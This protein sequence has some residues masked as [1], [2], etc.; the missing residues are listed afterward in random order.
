[1]GLLS[2]MTNGLVGLPKTK[3]ECDVMIGE[4]EKKLLGFSLGKIIGVKSDED[5]KKEMFSN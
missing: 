4:L 3:H 5:I 1:M 2:S